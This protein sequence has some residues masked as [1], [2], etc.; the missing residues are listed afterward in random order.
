MRKLILV[1][2]IVMLAISYTVSV[3]QN[4][5]PSYTAIAVGDVDSIRTGGAHTITMYVDL[6]DSISVVELKFWGAGNGYRDQW[7]NID[8][9]DTTITITPT[10]N[11]RGAV[12]EMTIRMPWF[13]WSIQTFTY[14]ALTSTAAE[15]TTA[16]FYVELSDYER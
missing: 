3:G 4:M 9:N 8:V 14:D 1:F 2:T 7:T 12:I 5:L 11:D 6:V 16:T 13:K 10:A 15:D